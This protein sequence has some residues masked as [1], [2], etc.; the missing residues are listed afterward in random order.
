MVGYSGGLGG[1]SQSMR[2]LI[3]CLVY[4]VAKRKDL[5]QYGSVEKYVV[6]NLT[7]AS[8]YIEYTRYYQ[9]QALFRPISTLGKSG[10]V[11]SYAIFK[12][13]SEK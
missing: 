7:E 11:H 10:T 6:S 9:A 1:N 12:G 13:A 4:S 5:K 2:G 8:S 3:A